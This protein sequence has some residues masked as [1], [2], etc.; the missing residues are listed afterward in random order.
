MADQFRVTFL[1]DRQHVTVAEGTSLL[2]A[3]REAGLTLKADC[4]GK[5]V[6]GKCRVVVR[7]GSVRT[8]VS[9]HLDDED[10]EGSVV[11]ACR[12]VPTT[13]VT[14]FVPPADADQ[15]ISRLSRLAAAGDETVAAD[16]LARQVSVALAEATVAENLS[17]EERLRAALAEHLDEAPLQITADAFRRLGPAARSQDGQVTAT[18]SWERGAWLLTDVAPG[19]KADAPLGAAIDVGTTTIVVHLVDL[20]SGETVDREAT[21][22]SQSAHGE[23]YITR[24]MTLD[25]GGSIQAMQQL[26]VGNINGLLTTMTERQGRSV[27]D[28]VSLVAAG[29]TPM[30]HFLLGLD[31]TMIRK[32]P[33]VPVT[34]DPPPIPAAEVGIQAAPGAR[35]VPLPG[36]AAFVGADITAGVLATKL[37]TRDAPTLLIDI[38][39]N[40]EI[41]L[42]NSDWMACASSSAGTAFEGTRFGMR[43]VPGAVERVRCID[44]CQ[45][46][47]HVIGDVKPRGLCGS[48]VLDLVAELF[49]VGVLQRDGR[50]HDDG[51][52][53]RLR[54]GE[55]ETEFVLAT[56][57][58]AEGGRPI[59]LTQSEIENVIRSKAGV[60][61]A[62][63]IL[64]NMF[65]VT[66]A[67]LDTVYLAGSFGSFIDVGHAIRI[68][69]LPEVPPERV[70]YVGNTSLMG[71]KRVLLARDALAEIGRVSGAMTYIDLMTNPAYMEEFVQAN[72]L[73]H[74]DPTR[75]PGVLAELGLGGV[76]C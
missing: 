63:Q 37:H 27:G 14:I 21:G 15:D 25:R 9:M 17:D 54:C 10:V 70:R 72:F 22:N 60:A 44:G 75:Y 43:G 42:G 64:M 61:A 59:Y 11:L 38:G 28:V 31:P 1:P 66:A 16:P 56:A 19:A 13:D 65:D 48:G 6:C 5:G 39:T 68:G 20:E 46:R 8:D 47:L 30:L 26:A 71:A 49:R 23:D 50:F 62:V 29:N 2:T 24:I 12:S 67:D 35:L 52:C 53:S 73:P 18:L 32:E 55:D 76:T 51:S 45:T 7:E 40:G 57:D 58:E 4:D 36:V 41:V 74:T 3:I 33:Y 69:L 34:N